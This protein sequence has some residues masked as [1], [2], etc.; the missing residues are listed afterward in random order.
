M[1]GSGQSCSPFARQWLVLWSTGLSLEHVFSPQPRG[2]LE[3]MGDDQRPGGAPEAID[4]AGDENFGV[5]AHE[6]A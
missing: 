3:V 2:G 5:S 1:G 4:A 6:T